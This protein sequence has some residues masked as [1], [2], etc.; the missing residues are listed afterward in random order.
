MF[1]KLNI[2]PVY[3]MTSLNI[4]LGSLIVLLVFKITLLLTNSCR[5]SLLCSF[6]FAIH[7]NMVALSTELQREIPYYFLLSLS[8]LFFLMFFTSKKIFCLV[9]SAVLFSL[10]IFIR[11]EAFELALIFVFFLIYFFLV[12]KITSRQ[13]FRVLFIYSIFVSVSLVILIYLFRIPISAYFKHYF[14]LITV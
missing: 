9:L 6:F 2:N 3:G 13:V 4:V 7:P 14:Q 5:S 12:Q 10:N 11:T 1:T 8:F